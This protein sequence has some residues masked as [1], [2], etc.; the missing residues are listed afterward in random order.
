MDCSRRWVYIKLS[1]QGLSHSQGIP[2]VTWLIRNNTFHQDSEESENRAGLQHESFIQINEIPTIHD[3]QSNN[4]TPRGSSL[5]K[6]SRSQGQF[7]DHML[8]GLR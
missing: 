8:V 4:E 6:R 2:H 7:M 5:G 3:I 1:V